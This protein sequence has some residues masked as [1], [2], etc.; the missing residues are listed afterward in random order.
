ME[1][2]LLRMSSGNL[3]SDP[4]LAL[5]YDR[6]GETDYIDPF[7]KHRFGNAA[8]ESGVSHHHRNNRV[9][10]GQNIQSTLRHRI[11]E[12]MGVRFQSISKLGGRH[13]E[14][15]RANRTGNHRGCNRIGEEIGSGSLPQ[16]LDHLLGP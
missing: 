10:T 2:L 7:L 1:Q 5:R 8:R 14:F 12:E 3:G 11:T 4:R 9:S 6:I 16:Q 15:Q 13:H